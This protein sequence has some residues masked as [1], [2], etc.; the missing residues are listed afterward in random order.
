MKKFNQ[1][2]IHTPNIHIMTLDLEY[3]GNIDVGG[4]KKCS[5]YEYDEK[6]CTMC[7]RCC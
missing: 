7:D 3:N 2:I 5:E 6:K 1:T 4:G